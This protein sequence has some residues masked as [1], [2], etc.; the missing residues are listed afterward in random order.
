MCIRDSTIT[1]T[2][3]TRAKISVAWTPPPLIEVENEKPAAD[4][5]VSPDYADVAAGQSLD[6]T[7]RFHPRKPNVYSLV[8]LEATVFY[9]SQRSFRLV[10]DAVLAPP[11]RL[12]VAASGHS[13][14][15]EQFA[16]A[17][18]SEP[19][20]RHWP[21]IHVGDAG[22]QSLKLKNSSNLPCLF[23]I[24]QDP[25]KAFTVRPAQGLIPPGGF[26]LLVARFEPKEERVYRHRVR[27]VV[28]G[29]A[30]DGPFLSVSYTHLT[31]PTILLV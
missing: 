26:Q 24:E 20:E 18:Q 23:S 7:V 17:L 10:N 29:E 28:N 31:L 2:N 15:G 9:K 13:F 19:R 21:G 25:V 11:W 8:D 5:S 12:E 30:C 27:L 3:T 1:V 6:F 14:G 4:F 22:Y 16:P